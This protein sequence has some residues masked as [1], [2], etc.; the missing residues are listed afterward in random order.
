MMQVMLLLLLLLYAPLYT[1]QT[2]HDSAT[3]I[4]QAAESIQP[5]ALH[6][7][8]SGHRLQLQRGPHAPT[9]LDM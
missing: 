5:A 9:A 4:K 6:T 8:G 7:I 3:G 2:A 1:P